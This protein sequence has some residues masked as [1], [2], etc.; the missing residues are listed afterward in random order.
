MIL[1]IIIKFWVLCRKKNYSSHKG[2]RY[3]FLII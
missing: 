3:I 1:K 2:Y